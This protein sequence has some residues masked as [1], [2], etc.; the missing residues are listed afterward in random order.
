VNAQFTNDRGM[1]FYDETVI[2]SGPLAPGAQTTVTFP[3]VTIPQRPYGYVKLIMMTQLPNDDHPENNKKSRTWS[4]G[5]DIYP[6]NTTV[7]LSGTMGQNDWYISNVQ[8]TLIATDNK[9]W[10]SGVD[11]TMYKIDNGDWTEYL[12]P[13]IVD[14]NS[15]QHFVYFFSV[16]NLG[17][18]EETQNISFKLDKTAP[19]FL[20]YSFIPLN[21]MKDKWMCSAIVEDLLS[22][23]EVVEFYVDGTFIGN[24]TIEPYECE[25][26]GK[27]TNN[28]QAVAYDTA[29]NSAFSPIASYYEMSYQT[30]Q[31]FQ[32]TLFSCKKM[33]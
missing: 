28:S 13:V 6:P 27:P 29:G 24:D 30:Q 2:I 9:G 33:M 31:L 17:N 19:V 15:I 14:R 22:G 1:I 12:F 7:V 21:F 3:D 20:N 18:T 11:Y 32:N 16:D 8:V 4:W 23:I 10:P 26:D 25:F 5:W